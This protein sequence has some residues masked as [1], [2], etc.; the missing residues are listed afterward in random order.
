MKIAN[1]VKFW[2]KGS[3]FEPIVSNL[4]FS[5]LGRTNQW[6]N[7]ATVGK[8]EPVNKFGDDKIF[9]AALHK[10]INQTVAS[11]QVFKRWILQ[12]QPTIFNKN[13]KKQGQKD[14][15]RS[16]TRRSQTSLLFS[17][18]IAVVKNNFE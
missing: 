2:L 18:L 16:G 6:Y 17:L 10:N 15:Q 1:Y 13:K 4:W 14:N 12:K 5:R 8:K 9:P 3:N 7:D 11:S